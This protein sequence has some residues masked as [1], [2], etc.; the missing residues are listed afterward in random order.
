MS[1]HDA[2]QLHQAGRHLETLNQPKTQY[3]DD[4][5]SI[6]STDLFD[7]PPVQ[8]AVPGKALLSAA[9]QAKSTTEPAEV[10]PHLD[11]YEPAQDTV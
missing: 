5:D 11:Q 10:A 3:E 9:V 2:E 6:G 4:A 1:V 8:Q 7:K